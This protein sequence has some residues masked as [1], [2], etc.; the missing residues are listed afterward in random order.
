M[1]NDDFCDLINLISKLISI[2]IVCDCKKKLFFTKK[3][4][5]IC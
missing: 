3:N 4:P 1:N 5:L 2:L